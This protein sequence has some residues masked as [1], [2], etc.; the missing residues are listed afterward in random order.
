[1]SCGTLSEPNEP[2]AIPKPLACAPAIV[3]Y[4]QEEPSLRGS[5]PQARTEEEATGI[6]NFLLYVRS[7]IDFG[8]EADRI[9]NLGKAQCID[10]VSGAGP[11]A[12][13]TR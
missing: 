2:V 5:I 11:Q 4:S 10:R 1:M 7:I 3:A 13:P 8:R 9:A 12:N 6:E